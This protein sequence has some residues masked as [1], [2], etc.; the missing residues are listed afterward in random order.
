[1]FRPPSSPHRSL[2]RRAWVG[3]VVALW[4][5]SP[6]SGASFG[7]EVDAAQSQIQFQ[8]QAAEPLS[9]ALGVALDGA[10]PPVAARTGLSVTAL[11]V[12]GAGLDIALDLAQANPGL[13]YLDPDGAF[14]IPLLFL[15]LDDGAA[16]ADLT[17]LDVTGTF[18]PSAACGGRLCLEST[19]VVDTGALGGLATVDLIAVPEPS[20]W[21]LG[22][23]TC[24]GWAALR[25]RGVEVNR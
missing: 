20:A 8:G 13:G 3:A 14:A 4:L 25:R 18:G 22:L 6:A 19:L 17:L 23:T 21:A 24:L 7:L 9:G 5:A 12:S 15:Q 1:M 16:T 10:G 2:P 11:S